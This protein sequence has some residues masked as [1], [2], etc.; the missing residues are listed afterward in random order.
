MKRVRKKSHLFFGLAVLILAIVAGLLVWFSFQQD[1]VDKKNI[2]WMYVIA[3]FAGVAGI[4]GIIGII[5][6]FAKTYEVKEGK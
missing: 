6:F 1:T 4:A 5:L 3:G 2:I